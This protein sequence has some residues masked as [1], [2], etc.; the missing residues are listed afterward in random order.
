MTAGLTILVD[1]DGPLAD[2]DAHFYKLCVDRGYPMHDGEVHV[3]ALCTEHR[4]ATDCLTKDH[5]R[6]ARQ[7][8]NESRWF[9]D[10]PVVSGAI[11][12]INALADHPDVAEVWIVTKPLEA[13]R[14][15]QS[16]KAH[17]VRTHLGEDWL[18]R[19][20]IAPDKSMVRGDI[21]LDDAPKPEWFPRA[22]WQPVI[23]PMSWNDA[24][25]THSA[26]HGLTEEPRWGWDDPLDELIGF[27][28]QGRKDMA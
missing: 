19:L 11:E 9:R 2:F 22:S 18:R 26:A 4:F 12:G 25:G 1:Q 7:H 8:V 24:D 28:R 5:G 10:L 6:L 17:W 15:C 23:F 16:D 20:I 21:L 13:N 27:D 14:W 3:D